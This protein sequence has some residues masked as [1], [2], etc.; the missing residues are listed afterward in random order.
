MKRIILFSLIAFS[1][2][3]SSQR[4]RI[5]EPV[6]DITPEEAMA[7]YDFDKAEE[8]LNAKI[9]YLT[10]KKQPTEHEDSLLVEVEKAKVRLQA[11]ESVTFIDSL[12]IPKEDLI[13]NLRL[14]SES[15]SIE[16]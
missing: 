2:T 6:F 4:R 13:S 10:K 5:V 3:A 9:D 11:T 1:L 15:G 7:Q 8:I 12:V 14:G 16:T